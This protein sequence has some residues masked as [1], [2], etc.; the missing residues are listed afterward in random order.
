MRMRAAS[1]RKKRYEILNY[2]VVQELCLQGFLFHDQGIGLS[3]DITTSKKASA[4]QL[5][6]F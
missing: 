5:E 1:I 6:P 3:V 4:I 2:I